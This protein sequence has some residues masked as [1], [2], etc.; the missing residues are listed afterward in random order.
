VIGRDA[1][2]TEYWHF[3]DDSSKLYLKFEHH[4]PSEGEN[5]A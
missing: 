5:P 2:Y 4:V 1:Q 3:K